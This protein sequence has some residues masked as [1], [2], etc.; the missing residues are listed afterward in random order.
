MTQLERWLQLHM[1]ME[2]IAISELSLVIIYCFLSSSTYHIMHGTGTGT[3][4]AYMEDT[5]KL[6]F[7]LSNATDEYTHKSV[8]RVYSTYLNYRLKYIILAFILRRHASY[9]QHSALFRVYLIKS[10]SNGI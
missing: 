9:L 10:L 7:G 8:S 4:A 3:N 5:K 6:V 2:E 1:R